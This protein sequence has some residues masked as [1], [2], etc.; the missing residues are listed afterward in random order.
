MPQRTRYAVVGLGGRSGMYSEA[1][2]KDYADRADHVIRRLREL[3]ELLSIAPRRKL[4]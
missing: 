1:I 2:L 3:L 4:V